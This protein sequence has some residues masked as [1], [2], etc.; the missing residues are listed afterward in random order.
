MKK[1]MGM[2]LAVALIF[3]A[4]PVFA[5][6]Y[7]AQGNAYAYGKEDSILDKVSD[8]V[9][10][11]GKSESEKDEILTERRLDRAMKRGAQAFKKSSKK[12]SKAMKEFEK[13]FEKAFK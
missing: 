11:L 9:A 5:D 3:G 1:W 12:A 10:T 7:K 13:D 4:L 2:V 6:N 8:W